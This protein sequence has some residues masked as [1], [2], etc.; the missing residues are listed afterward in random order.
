MFKN[1]ASPDGGGTESNVS[2]KGAAR[3]PVMS[4]GPTETP[5]QIIDRV[6]GFICWLCQVFVFTSLLHFDNARASLCRLYLDIRLR[7]PVL[8]KIDAFFN[9]R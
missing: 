8:N 9:G 7:I 1:T 6:N 2:N 3:S 5:D 4:A